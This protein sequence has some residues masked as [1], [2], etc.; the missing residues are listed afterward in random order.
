MTVL[1][2]FSP[3]ILV[4]SKGRKANNNKTIA[5]EYINLNGEE[6]DGSF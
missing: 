4:T 1:Y 2:I 3:Y 5:V 6:L